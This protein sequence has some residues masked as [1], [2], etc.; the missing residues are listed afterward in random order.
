MEA[1][2]READ[3]R[4]TGLQR[5]QQRFGG[6]GL[7]LVLD[8]DV[9]TEPRA[10]LRGEEWSPR[11]HEIVAQAIERGG[12]D[13]VGDAAAEVDQPDRFGRDGRLAAREEFAARG[14]IGVSGRRERVEEREVRGE[15]VALGREISTALSVE[16]SESLAV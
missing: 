11:L 6:G 12:V 2:D 1:D 13:A 5:V 10:V 16:E 15:L 14:D 4:K 3:G 7:G 8:R 9:R